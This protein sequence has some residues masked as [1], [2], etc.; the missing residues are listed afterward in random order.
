LTAKWED[1]GPALQMKDLHPKDQK[2]LKR[3]TGYFGN[4]A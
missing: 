2:S 3:K 1:Q 4:K